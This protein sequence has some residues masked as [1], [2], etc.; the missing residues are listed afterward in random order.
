MLRS[1]KSA[2]KAMKVLTKENVISIFYDYLLNQWQKN[3]SLWIVAP[4]KV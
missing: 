2:S 1:Y 4:Y 3:Q